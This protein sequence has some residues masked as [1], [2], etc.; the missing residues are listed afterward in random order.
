MAKKNYI[1]KTL[2][3]LVK[4]LGF[5]IIL[6]NLYFGVPPY[7]ERML[8]ELLQSDIGLELLP[9]GVLLVFVGEVLGLVKK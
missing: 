2:S 7:Y 5:G 3:K 8:P 9:F 1:M 6:Y 4:V